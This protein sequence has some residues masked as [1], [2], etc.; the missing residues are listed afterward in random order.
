MYYPSLSNPSSCSGTLNPLFCAV[1]RAT[2]CISSS[3]DDIIAHYRQ[4]QIAANV[5]LMDPV[6]KVGD[7]RGC[8]CG[9]VSWWI[10]VRVCLCGCASAFVWVCECFCVCGWVGVSE[11][12]IDYVYRV[13]AFPSR[14]QCWLWWHSYSHAQELIGIHHTYGQRCI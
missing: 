12:C 5:Y 6:V 3:L 11:L 13:Q 7:M 1:A 10:G 8:V 9:D 2:L 4:C 14:M